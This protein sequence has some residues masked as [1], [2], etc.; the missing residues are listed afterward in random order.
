MRTVVRAILAYL[1]H[2]VIEEAALLFESGAWEEM[3][4]NILILASEETRIRRILKRD[5]L[6]RDEVKA[7]FTSQI[8]PDQAAKM[9]DRIIHNDENEFLIPQIL[10][11]DQYL[12]DII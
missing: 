4:L 1:A 8:E 2:N 7:R 11:V 10:K 9:A 12:R 5:K 3:D 6:K